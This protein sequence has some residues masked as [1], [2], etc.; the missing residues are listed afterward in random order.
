MATPLAVVS[1]PF[2]QSANF[3]AVSFTVPTITAGNN[4]GDLSFAVETIAGMLMSFAISVPASTVS[5]HIFMKV[6]QS[7][8]SVY[9]VVTIT[10]IVTDA[11]VYLNRLPYMN[12]DTIPTGTLYIQVYNTGGDTS[13]AMPCIMMLET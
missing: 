11:V 3:R 1:T 10:G 8:G 13:G 4:S 9:E 6:G 5:V 7:V 2:P 12:F